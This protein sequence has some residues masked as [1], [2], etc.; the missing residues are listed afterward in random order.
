MPAAYPTAAEIVTYFGDSGFG[1][2][3]TPQATELI[4]SAIAEFERLCQRIPFIA[5]SGT[6]YF[7]T[8]GRRANDGYRVD[9]KEFTVLA[10]G[11]AVVWVNEQ[12]EEETLESTDFDFLP[13]N[14]GVDCK[15][16]E[17]IR[18]RYRFYSGKL[19]ITGLFGYSTTIP[20]DVYDAVRD[21]CVVLWMRKLRAAGMIT[22]GGSELSKEKVGQVEYTYDKTTV[23]SFEITFK[24]VAGRHELL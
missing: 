24:E 6:K 14:H 10:S 23:S 7:D 20:Q 18:L 4:T 16:F 12:N 19:K 8:E 2:I 1:I 22:A 5:A 17:A 13:L 21:Y 9:L 15:P 11:V 3:T